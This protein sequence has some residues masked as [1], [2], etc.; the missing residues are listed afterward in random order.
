MNLGENIYRLRTAKN[1]SQGELADALEVS[2]QSVSKWENNG[3]VPE[4][5]K[6]IK[7]S[8]IFGV[9]LDGLVFS[10]PPAEPSA[11]PNPRSSEQVRTAVTLMFLLFGMVL[12]LLSI[13]WGDHLRFGEEVGEVSSAIIVLISIAA[14]ARYNHKVLGFCAVMY[15]LYSIVCFGILNVTSLTNYCFVAV[16]GTV[17]LVWFITWGLHE[18]AAGREIKS[19]EKE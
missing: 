19:E 7:M 12:F 18:N 5:D 17:L 10:A 13:F 4:L 9:T 11:A 8:R 2:R 15:F 1:M 16:A 6:L 14:L 3:A